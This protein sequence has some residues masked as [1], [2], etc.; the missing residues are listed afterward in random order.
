MR[1]T[2]IT[3]S[4]MGTSTIEID[5]ESGAD[6]HRLPT[7][8]EYAIIRAALEIP[9]NA[10]LRKGIQAF[11]EIFEPSMKTRFVCGDT[12][13]GWEFAHH[14][15]DHLGEEKDEL[16]KDQPIERVAPK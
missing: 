13:K 10:D 14:V 8:E 5:T 12:C 7:Q 11:K 9:T 4:K 6:A 2:R 15:R 3:E 1:I 16:V